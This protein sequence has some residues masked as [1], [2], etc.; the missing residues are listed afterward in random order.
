MVE[1]V[2]GQKPGSTVLPGIISCAFS[3][4]HVSL[5]GWLRFAVVREKQGFPAPSFTWQKGGEPG[6]FMQ[7]ASEKER[8]VPSRNPAGKH[9]EAADGRLKGAD[10]KQELHERIV[11][12]GFDDKGTHRTGEVNREF[13]SVRSPQGVHHI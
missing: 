4:P 2:F 8:G 9:P 13:R 7:A 1:N 3:V 6:T 12:V 5:T 10:G 11:I